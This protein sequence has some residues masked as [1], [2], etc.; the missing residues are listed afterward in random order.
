MTPFSSP[1]S[2]GFVFLITITNV[3]GHGLMVSPAPRTGTR[4]AGG[5][6]GPARRIS[7]EHLNT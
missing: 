4:N 1:F 5:N 3:L 7:A 2:M 6:K